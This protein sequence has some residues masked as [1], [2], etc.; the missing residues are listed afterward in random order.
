MLGHDEGPVGVLGLEGGDGGLVVE[1]GAGQEDATADSPVADDL[2]PVVLRER[3]REARD[4][5]LARHAGVLRGGHRLA[6]ESGAALAEVE[7]LLGGERQAGELSVAGRDVELLG[8]L[9]DKR[10]GA[11][12]AGFVHL[13]VERGAVLEVDVLRVLT[14]QLEDRIDRRVEVERGA[15][16]RG[17][18]VLDQ[19]GADERA[20]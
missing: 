14:A 20:D 3:G 8:Q 5:H 17:D 13:V 4:D 1:D 10:A 18:L 11:G 16:L 7:L 19:V 6:H 15:R 9:V 2:R 12:G